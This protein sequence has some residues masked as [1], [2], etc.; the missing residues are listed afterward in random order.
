MDE[1]LP[2]YTIRDLITDDGGEARAAQTVR[3]RRK[4]ME[5]SKHVFSKKDILFIVLAALAIL[6]FGGFMVPLAPK[7]SS[8]SDKQ[9]GDHQVRERHLAARCGP[10]ETHWA[11]YPGS[12]SLDT[13]ASSLMEATKT[14]TVF[15]TVTLVSDHF[16]TITVT[17]ILPDAK[18]VMPQSSLSPGPSFP[19]N[20]T[21]S[22]K[23]EG[24][25]DSYI[26]T[27]PTTTVSSTT[28]DTAIEPPSSSTA[29]SPVPTENVLTT[30]SVASFETDKKPSSAFPVTASSMEIA[31]IPGDASLSK[32]T[33]VEPPAPSS[34]SAFSI[35]AN[36]SPEEC[37]EVWSNTT[38]A[39]S[40]MS[41]LESAPSTP[42]SSSLSDPIVHSV[43]APTGLLAP[44]S[45]V[46]STELVTSLFQPDFPPRSTSTTIVVVKEGTSTA[47]IVTLVATNG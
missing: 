7:L 6:C 27:T 43:S 46:Y 20:T 5:D 37:L 36:T 33:T 16:S 4:A 8:G 41:P 14:T 45:T 21:T 11:A 10:T 12:K 39:G 29:Q 38:S 2:K 19:V 42:T 17:A 23:Q 26:W 24:P 1:T 22:G 3:A 35:E 31:S 30:S 44:P 47:P 28:S 25:S 18:S 32:I 40:T 13:V 15:S 34:F 9:Q